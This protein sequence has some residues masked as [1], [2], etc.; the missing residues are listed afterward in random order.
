MGVDVNTGTPS[1]EETGYYSVERGC[2]IMKS[3]P[4]DTRNRYHFRIDTDGNLVGDKG[5]VWI[6][7]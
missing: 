7:Q 6:K 5:V 2:V 4:G 3:T 1:S